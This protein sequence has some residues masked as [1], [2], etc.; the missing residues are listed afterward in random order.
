MEERSAFVDNLLKD[1]PTEQQT[2]KTLEALGDYIMEGISHSDKKEHRY[3]T[4]NR[5]L[6]INKRETSFESLV[7]KF[8]NGEDGL[9][10][11]IIDDK[12]ALLSPKIEITAEDIDNV[13]GLRELRETIDQVQAR[14]DRAMGR[15]KYILKKQLI[16]LQRDQYILK[17]AYRQPMATTPTSKSSHRIELNETRGIGADGEPYSTSPVSLFNPSHISALL[18]HY[19]ALNVSTKGRPSDDF[20]CL[21][22]EFEALVERTFADNP[23]F[24]EI[25]KQKIAG[26]TN[27][28]IR[29]ILSEKY[30]VHY[31][32]EYI[33]TLYRQKIPKALAEQAKSDYLIWYY[34]F[35]HPELATWKTCPSCGES[36]LAHK[37]FFSINSTSKDGFY[38]H[39]KQCRNSKNKRKEAR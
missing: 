17:T 9:Y 37:R 4:P 18:T 7:D 28:E 11:L 6:T 16:E 5:Q 21:L 15:D 32:S 20:Y 24:Y 22:R 29:D 14:Y 12:N 30:S 25:I 13:P 39:C 26:K 3:L 31:A 10:N 38:S 23:A 8:E 35:E 1:L 34:T 33:S 36:K 2:P 19:S 27:E